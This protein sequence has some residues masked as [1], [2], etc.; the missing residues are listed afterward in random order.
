MKRHDDAADAYGRAI[1]V[2]QAQNLKSELWTLLLLRAECAEDGN[3]GR[4]QAG[5]AAGTGA[6][7]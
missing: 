3:G 2:A 7:A 1:A 5:A 6:R 4:R